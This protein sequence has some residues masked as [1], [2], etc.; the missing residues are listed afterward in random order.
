MIAGGR[1]PA[2]AG[3]SAAGA[4]I[5][6]GGDETLVRAV[7]RIDLAGAIAGPVGRGDACRIGPQCLVD[8]SDRRFM[9][10]GGGTALRPPHIRGSDQ[11]EHENPPDDALQTS[12][13]PISVPIG[14]PIG[15]PIG[16]TIP[17]HA[18]LTLASGADISP[19]LPFVTR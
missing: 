18:R 15:A 16:T 13:A 4:Q 5:V 12:L 8:G 14:A 17:A 7:D 2:A 9:A 6:D 10:I 11:R 1:R 19:L 3:R